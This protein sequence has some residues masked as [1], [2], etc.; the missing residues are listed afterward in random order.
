MAEITKLLGTV[1]ARIKLRKRYLKEFKG[2]ATSLKLSMDDSEYKLV[3]E[4]GSLVKVEGTADIVDTSPSPIQISAKEEAE[5][6]TLI[7]E[8]MIKKEFNC[9]DGYATLIDDFSRGSGLT[10][11]QLMP[12]L[13]ISPDNSSSE[14]I[15]DTDLSLTCTEDE[16]DPVY[17]PSKY[18]QKITAPSRKSLRRS[19]KK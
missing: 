9:S 8:N 19:C 18:Y 6:P 12:L 14:D 4:D 7:F 5:T 11:G 13:D 2:N 1:G 16:K 15:A 10:A 3:G 17:E